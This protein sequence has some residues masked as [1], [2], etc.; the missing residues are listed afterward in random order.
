MALTCAIEAENKPEAKKGNRDGRES[1][2]L[3]YD[4]IGLN[5]TKFDEIQWN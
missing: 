4:R 5:I 3:S 2:I 1:T